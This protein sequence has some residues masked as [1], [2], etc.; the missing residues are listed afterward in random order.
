MGKSYQVEVTVTT[1]APPMTGATFSKTQNSITVTIPTAGNP[2]GATYG[3]ELRT[4]AGVFIEDVVT[5]NPGGTLPANIT[6][7]KTGLMPQTPYKCRPF[8]DDGED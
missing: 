5:V 1:E 4:N 7:T 2:V 8:I 3:F 6:A